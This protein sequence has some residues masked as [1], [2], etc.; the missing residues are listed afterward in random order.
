MH[1]VDN[2]KMAIQSHPKSDYF[3]PK[4]SGEYGYLRDDKTYY[5]TGN[6]VSK[7]HSETGFYQMFE[8]L[9]EGEIDL[10]RI[11]KENP[12]RIYGGI[13]K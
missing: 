1:L 3:Y 8:D 2:S 13:I 12:A 11:K 4:A 6:S 10:V 7:F 5:L 9:N